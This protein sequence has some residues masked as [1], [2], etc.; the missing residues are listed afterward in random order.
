MN[1]IL[2][3]LSEFFANIDPMMNYDEIKIMSSEKPILIGI[4][5]AN[6]CIEHIKLT[7]EVRDPPTS[8]SRHFGDEK[9]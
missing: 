7:G 4:Y 6:R 8:R 3:H 5:I 2:N 1:D 9:E